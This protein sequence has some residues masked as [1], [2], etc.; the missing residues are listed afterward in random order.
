MKPTLKKLTVSALFIALLVLFQF[1]TSMMGQFVTGSLVNLTLIASVLI[2]GLSVGVVVAV[3]SPLFAFFLGIGPKFLQLIPII[4]LGNTVL[5]LLYGVLVK[6]PSQM[7]SWFAAIPIATIVKFA[8]LYLGIVKLALPMIPA[9]SETQKI[10]MGAS[11]S[12]PQLVTAAIGG[13]LSFL[14]VPPVQRAVQ[15]K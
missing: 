2:G 6:Q 12:W 1:S 13:V 15:K 10:A 11:F 3:L 9:L 14:I 5:V 7:K 8:V 4:M